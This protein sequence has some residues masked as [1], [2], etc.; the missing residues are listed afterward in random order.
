M[1]GRWPTWLPERH[2]WQRGPCGG[3]ECHD[4]R[5]TIHVGLAHKPTSSGL[6]LLK[7]GADAAA[8]GVRTG[9][10][11]S[12]RVMQEVLNDGRRP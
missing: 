8:Q 1:I 5:L 4:S 11:S 10:L 12:A 6:S 3:A 7:S 9:R 2:A